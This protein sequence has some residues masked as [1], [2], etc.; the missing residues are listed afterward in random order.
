M[1]MHY[2][3]SFP[4]GGSHHPGGLGGR[5]VPPTGGI[6][7]IGGVPGR[8]SAVGEPGRS[9]A[10]GGPGGYLRLPGRMAAGLLSLRVAPYYYMTPGLLLLLLL[11]QHTGEYMSY[12]FLYIVNV[13]L[14]PVYC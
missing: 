9:S 14:I 4:K 13:I 7:A 1:P 12:S 2:Y 10:I 5:T 3:Y 11:T 8:S 6:R